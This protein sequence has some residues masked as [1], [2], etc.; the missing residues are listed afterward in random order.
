MNSNKNTSH[1]YILYAR[2]SSESEDRQIQSIDDQITRLKELATNYNLKIVEV[3]TESKSAKKP[4]N[5]PIFANLIEKLENGEAEGILCWQIN[6]LSRNPI[7]SARIQ[8]MLQ[9]GHLKSIMT[10]E[11]EYRPEDNVLLFNVESGM[12]NQFILDLSKNVK[13]GN[14]GK[15]ERGW[16][17]GMA[18]IGYLNKLDDHTIIPDPERFDLMRKAWDLMLTG[19]YTVPQIHRKLNNEWGFLTVKK[20]RSGNKPISLSGLYRIFTSPF[21]AGIIVHGGK[22]YPGKHQKMIT[23]DE[24]DQVQEILGRKGKPRPKTHFFAFTGMI[25]CGVCGCSITAETKTKIN[26]GDKRI[27]KYTYYHCTRKKR[28]IVCN[29][30]F[31][32]SETELEKQIDQE[33]TKITILPEFKEWALEGLSQEND[34]EIK[35]RSAIYEMQHTKLEAAQRQLDNLTKM[36]YRELIDDETFIKERDVLQNEITVLKRDTLTIEDRAENWMELTE[37]TFQFA[38]HARGHFLNGTKEEKKNVLSALGSNLLLKDKK[39]T[40]IANKC[41]VPIIEH[42]PALEEEY[43]RLEPALI[44]LT[45][46]KTEALTSVITRWQARR[47]SDPR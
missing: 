42:Y 40:I 6:R 32:V 35:E 24:F 38:V 7:D 47:E 28:D 10:T 45:K 27:R 21:C 39:L 36:R 41:F 5:R 46:V 43:K 19:A 14:Q 31:G 15:L 33:L 23:L 16:R 37:K 18:P 4:D 30:T 34:Q 20:K 22:E 17:P 25:R 13:R 2:K 1:R 3:L 44:G 12:A 8:W 11:R 26:K 9:Q 29:Q